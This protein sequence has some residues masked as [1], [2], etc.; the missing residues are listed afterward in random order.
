MR[1]CS[2]LLKF[3][4]T[5]CSIKHV[6]NVLF[7]CDREFC[8]SEMQFLSFLVEIKKHCRVFSFTS[9]THNTIFKHN[10]L[11]QNGNTLLKFSSV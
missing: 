10:V 7:I 6:L 5:L 4:N 1:H 3:C 11:C 2:L 9:F 8:I